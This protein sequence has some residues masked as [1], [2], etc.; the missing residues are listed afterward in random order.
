VATTTDSATSVTDT[1]PS[2]FKATVDP[3]IDPSI[4]P[5]IEDFETTAEFRKLF[6]VWKEAKLKEVLAYLHNNWGLEEVTIDRLF[7]THQF[8][9]PD[10]K[11]RNLYGQVAPGQA[12]TDFEGKAVLHPVTNQPMLFTVWRKVDPPAT[13]ESAPETET[14]TSES[15]G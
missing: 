4:D 15:I 2:N 11:N 9:F 12:F 14:E 8:V 6:Q 5:L 1:L 13:P 10:R 3:S 7:M